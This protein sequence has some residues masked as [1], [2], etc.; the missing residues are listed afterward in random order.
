MA[1]QLIDLFGSLDGGFAGASRDFKILAVCRAPSPDKHE[2]DDGDCDTVR[3]RRA[4]VC[5]P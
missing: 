4:L 3:C 2:V 5:D 1:L